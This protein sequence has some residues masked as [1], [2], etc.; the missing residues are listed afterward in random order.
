MP[1]LRS[2]ELRP[3]SQITRI[4]V[5]V[6]LF[7]VAGLRAIT[8]TPAARFT[9]ISSGRSRRK[10]NVR[11]SSAADETAYDAD[12]NGDEEKIVSHLFNTYAAKAHGR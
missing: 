3:C 4:E 9:T 12:P 5:F 6:D 1:L 8:A 11:I 7:D 10:R 2:W